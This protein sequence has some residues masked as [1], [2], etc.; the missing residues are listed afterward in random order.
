MTEKKTTIELKKLNK[1][2]GDVI[3]V[4]DVSLKIS[5]ND[6][7]TILGPS[8]CGKSTILRLIA[9]L[10]VQDSGAVIINNQGL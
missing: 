8:G 1:K 3:A 4:N 2:F 7:F 6:F 10:E 9:G 5:E